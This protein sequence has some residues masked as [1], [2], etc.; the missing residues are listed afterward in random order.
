MA[1][2]ID[3]SQPTDSIVAK[4]TIEQEELGHG[5]GVSAGNG[6]CQTFTRGQDTG[7]SKTVTFSRTYIHFLG[8]GTGACFETNQDDKICMSFDFGGSYVNYNYS[9]ASVRPNHLWKYLSRANSYRLEDHSFHTYD[10][11]TSRDEIQSDGR[12]VTTPQPDSIEVLKNKV[13]NFR[14]NN[15][16]PV[17]IKSLFDLNNGFRTVEPEKSIDSLLPR[18]KLMLPLEQFQNIKN[19]SLHDYKLRC[20]DVYN[21]LFSVEHWNTGSDYKQSHKFDSGRISVGSFAEMTNLGCNKSHLVLCNKLLDTVWGVQANM[22]TQTNRFPVLPTPIVFFRFAPYY[23]ATRKAGRR[24]Q[25]K[26]T[27]STTMTFYFSGDPGIEIFGL[28]QQADILSTPFDD[29]YDQ[30]RSSITRFN[31]GV[32]A[33]DFVMPLTGYILKD[34]QTAYNT[35]FMA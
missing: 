29:P 4:N 23:T 28:G 33:E 16:K 21:S 31:W 10:L 20:F 9:R 2:H 25:F 19:E 22:A 32:H 12:I 30:A 17:G 35:E 1:S 34:K 5:Q 26:C 13:G 27:Y 24:A 8:Q 18:A 11:I 14:P 7:H 15:V 6:I 3:G